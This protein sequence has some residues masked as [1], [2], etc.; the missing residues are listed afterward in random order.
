MNTS[1]RKLISKLGRLNILP[2]EEVKAGFP[3]KETD[4]I[5]T[6]NDDTKV[7]VITDGITDE[8]VFLLIETEKLK[9]LKSIKTMI[10]G[11]IIFFAINYGLWI[12]VLLFELGK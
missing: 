10:K 5:I 4:V 7:R 12:F 9:T 1:N 6:K 2:T 3:Y 8:E 11:C